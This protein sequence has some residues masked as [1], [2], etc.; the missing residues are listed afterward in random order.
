MGIE[1]LTYVDMAERL[2]ISADAARGLARRMQLP[3]Q[4]TD[5]GKTLVAVDLS[6]IRNKPSPMV[7][8]ADMDALRA[9]VAELRELVTKAEAM[10]DRQRADYERERERAE[11]LAAE[12]Q[13]IFAELVAA[14]ERPAV[15]K[16]SLRSSEHCRGGCGYSTINPRMP[17]LISSA[18]LWGYV[19]VLTCCEGDVTAIPRPNAFLI[20]L[21]ILRSASAASLCPRRGHRPRR[22]TRASG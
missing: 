16:V 11:S 19:E 7:R 8:R 2:N 10:A 20:A 12:I 22:L 1:Q 3:R 21:P 18:R 5:S 15:W 9:Q 17:P 13:R 14:K 4:K 6:E